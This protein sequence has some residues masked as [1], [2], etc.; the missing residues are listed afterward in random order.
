[1]EGTEVL[2][3]ASREAEDSVNQRERC[4]DAGSI[5]AERVGMSAVVVF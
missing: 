2:K 5:I 1:M 4:V 3:S